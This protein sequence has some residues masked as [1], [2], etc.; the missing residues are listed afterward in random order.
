MLLHR[1]VM[2]LMLWAVP[3]LAE[4]PPVIPRTLL[5]GNAVRDKPTLSPDGEK[6]AWVAPDT[7]GVMQVWVRTLQ[8]QDDTRAVTKEPQR[9]VRYYEWSQ[10]SRTLLYPQDSDGDENTHVYA[11]DLSTGVV[12]DLTPFQGIRARMLESSPTTPREL[13]VTMNLRART[14][15][16]IYRVSLDTGA[17]TLDTQDPGDVMTWT[18]DAKLD[19]R[20][21]LAQKPDGTTVLRVRDSPRTPWRTLLEVPLRENVFPQYMGFIG[22]SRDGAK[23]YLKSPHG[24][25]T[26]RVVERVLRTGAE[27]VL[28]EDAGSDVFD[29]LFHPERKVV[30]A[31]AFNTDGHV[32]WKVLDPS[33]REDF[34]VL[35]RMGD[36]DFSLVSRDRADR[37]WV[38]AFEQDAAPLRYYTYD[39]STRRAEL[40][41]SNQPSLEQAPLARMKP[42]QLKSRDGL[43]LTGYLTR[44]VD[45]PEGPLPT[46]LLVHGGPWTRDTWR[47]S[48]EVQWLANRGYAVL[49]VNFRS[50]AGLGKAFL[51]AGNRQWGRAM[52]DDLEDTVAWAVKEG[53]VDASRVAIMGSSYGGYAALA[54]A[55]FSPSVYRCAVDAFGISNLFTFLKSFPPQWQVIRGSY[56]QRVG[57]VEDPAEQ[58][59]LRATSPVFSVDKIRIPLL[60][61]QGANDPRVKQAESEQMV[62]AMEKAGRDVT[63][64][65][66]PDEGHGF[67]RPENNLDYHARVES[68]LAR[69]LGGRLE[70]LPKEGRVPGSS[71]VVRQ[72]GGTAK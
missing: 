43:T 14:S 45:A 25:N 41:F 29:V 36:G 17:I 47:F 58:E 10:D 65:L 40:L 60:V 61:A 54:G 57:D 35:G 66:Y 69:H 55:A 67:Y 20:G 12:R 23:V 1:G 37:R 5:F 11:A 50:S 28:A 46:V 70:P 49:Q 19:V 33:L 24:S 52:N 34:E 26:S 62:S 22:F 42:F 13:L 2:V 63:Y 8:G 6:L 56:A 44:P 21:A 7:K 9:G 68:F 72:S 53:Q 18:A 32:R 59:R 64:V 48:P 39:R 30:Q 31:V 71:A 4:S 27:K 3:A 38:V 51:N 15:S 16:D